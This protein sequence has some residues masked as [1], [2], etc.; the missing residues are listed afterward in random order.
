MRGC[1]RLLYLVHDSQTSPYADG[2]RFAFVRN[3]DLFMSAL[4][5]A[6]ASGIKEVMLMSSGG[7]V[8]GTM[9]G[10]PTSEDSPPQPVSA[11]GLAKLAM[12]HYLRI[13]SAARG[14]S[15]LVLRASNPYGPGQTALRNQ[16][17][18]PIFLRRAL[19]GQPLEIWGT[20]A[21]TKDYI[22][23]SDFVEA[24]VRLV[25]AG[26][27]NC[28][29]NV[30]SGRPSSLA[31]IIEAVEAAVGRRCQ[32]KL[33]PPRANDIPLVRL[34]CSRL[35]QRISWAPRTNLAE[36]IRRTWEW[37]RSGAPP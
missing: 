23:I 36:G 10:N 26:F 8:Y 22:Y 5:A 18:I 25:E 28:C 15:Y 4:E 27:D 30:C 35:H 7:A 12:E 16:G 19:E 31:D 17:V 6:A 14:G 20:P 34:D 32:V 24:A 3:L 37:M 11:Y 2:D 9:G 29:Y 13:F 21:I 33:L 1:R